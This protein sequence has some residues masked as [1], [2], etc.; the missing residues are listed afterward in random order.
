MKVLLSGFADQAA[1]WLTLSVVVI[2]AIGAP[3]FGQSR[4]GLRPSFEV[5]SI[6]PS[7][8]NSGVTARVGNG[9]GGG[10]NVTLKM[11]VAA[12]Y[13]VQEFQIVG[14]PGWI[15]SDRFDVEGKAENPRADPDQLRL[16][17]QSLL[18]DRFQLKLHRENK[19][20]PIYALVVAKD[21]PKINLAPDQTSPPVNGPAQ[22][23]AGPNRGAMRIGGGTLVGNAV[24]LS[25]FTR[26]LSQRLDRTVVDK[27]NLEGRFDIRLNWTPDVGEVVLD[28]G[29][30]PL[31]PAD[32]TGPSIFT[33]IQEQLGL[34]LES[35]RG[36]VDLIIIDGV[37]KLSAN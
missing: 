9:Q 15:G 8:T 31:P 24:T 11:L 10:R 28:P 6:K 19:E 18:E 29:G 3:S 33:A 36:P 37:E 5:A 12:A 1:F 35:I 27:T 4:S 34:R 17:L 16:M 25:L 13:R 30:N 22:Q 7:K 20:A 21:G 26:L 14:G 32:A 2:A 23:G